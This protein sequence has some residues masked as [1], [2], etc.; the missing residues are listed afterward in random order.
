MRTR[1]EKT[2]VEPEDFDAFRTWQEGVGRG[3]RAYLTVKPGRFDPADVSLLEAASWLTPG[4]TDS[5][6]LL[7]R[8]YLSDGRAEDA[9]RVLARAREFRPGERRLW[10]LSAEAVEGNEKVALWREAVKHFPA[11]GRFALELARGLIDQGDH[12]GARKALEPLTKTADG[13]MLA[14]AWHELALVELDG[15]RPAKALE[16]LDAARKADAASARKAD[17][18]LTRADAHEALKEYDKAR[19]ALKDALDDDPTSGD[20]LEGLVRLAWLDGDGP[21]ALKHLRQ[22]AALAGD[23][24]QWLAKTGDWYQRL[25]RPDEAA[26]LASKATADGELLPLARRTLGLVALGRGD[27]AG[28]LDHLDKAETDAVVVEARLRAMFVLGRLADASDELKT[29][30]DLLA[31][32]GP[33]LKR[34]AGWVADAQKRATT[35]RKNGKDTD[36]FDRAVQKTACAGVLRGLDDVSLS[37]AAGPLAESA[38]AD[39]PTF[40][41]A[42]ALRAQ[43]FLEKG[44]LTRALEDAEK[45]IAAGP[46]DPQAH[47]VR[48]RVLLERG[49]PAEAAAELAKATEL[50]GRTDPA[51]LSALADALAETGKIPEALASARAAL[52][53]RPTDEELA[54]Q[55]KRLAALTGKE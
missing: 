41:P 36:A 53:L 4:D 44:K 12:A 46:P 34:A 52:K 51:A 47:F 5:A 23:D 10:E 38:L 3:Y 27:P 42:L 1:L 15:G 6:V 7:A 9:A 16:C 24:P 55:V 25:G 14:E 28:A 40:G 48:G 26:D 33:A 17:F 11:D 37:A 45:A 43:G 35:L 21:A 31:D 30:K 49:K 22:L 8:M 50:S 20:A 18:C 13:A 39:V 32:A 54:A 19:A 2:R 29:S